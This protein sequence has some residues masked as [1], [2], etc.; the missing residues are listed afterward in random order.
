MHTDHTSAHFKHSQ[1]KI[2]RYFI[3]AVSTE[4]QPQQKPQKKNLTSGTYIWIGFCNMNRQN[5]AKTNLEN[6]HCCL[7]S[8]TK[9]FKQTL[10]SCIYGLQGF[11][12][13]FPPLVLVFKIKLEKFC[14]LNLQHRLA[15]TAVLEATVQSITSVKHS[16]VKVCRYTS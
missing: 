7:M 5:H 4:A 11:C 16:S 6:N 1:H 3:S 2:T 9:I 8:P 13:F 12:F 10:N 15:T 14:F